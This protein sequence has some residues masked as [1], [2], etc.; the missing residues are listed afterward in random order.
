MDRVAHI[1][2]PLAGAFA[3]IL[4]LNCPSLLVTR[5]RLTY[6]QPRTNGV[7]KVSGR[8]LLWCIVEPLALWELGDIHKHPR[9]P[10]AIWWV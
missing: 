1:I 7:Y 10:P 5:L 9:S 3:L 4:I 2:S 8:D 6:R